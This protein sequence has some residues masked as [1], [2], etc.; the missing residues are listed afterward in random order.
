MVRA[1]AA[2]TEDLGSGPS[3]NMVA[4]TAHNSSFIGYDAFFWLA[5]GQVVHKHT[6]G[7]ITHVY[8][9]KYLK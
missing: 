3:T 6:C 8:K 7:Q 9:N 1:P 5:Q 2:L 4:Q